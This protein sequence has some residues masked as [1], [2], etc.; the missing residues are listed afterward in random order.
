MV[1]LSLV[2]IAL[3]CSGCANTESFAGFKLGQPRDDFSCSADHRSPFPP[4]CDP[5]HW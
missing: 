2:A 1:G 4:Y 5:E 3:F